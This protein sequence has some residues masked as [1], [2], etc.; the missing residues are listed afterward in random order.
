M[1]RSGQG[2]RTTERIQFHTMLND[3]L[4]V[5]DAILPCA[6]GCF[7]SFSCDKAQ[8]S[9]FIWRKIW[10]VLGLRIV[11]KP[12]TGLVSFFFFLFIS[13]SCCARSG[14]APHHVGCDTRD[15]YYYDDYGRDE[16]YCACAGSRGGATA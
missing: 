9:N 8:L 7:L 6:Q 5:L 3:G 12:K 4:L 14:S 2:K 13:L 11:S 1:K 16:F 15:D 10:L